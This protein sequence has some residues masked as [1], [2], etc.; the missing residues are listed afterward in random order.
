[1]ALNLSILIATIP[2]RK[3]KF[4]RLLNLLDSQMPMNG[5]IEI[6]WD[7]SL[8]YNIGVKRNKL[9]DRALG[10]YIVFVDDDDMVSDDYVTKILQATKY[11]PDCIG[12]SG[13]ITTNKKNLK[14]W[15]ISKEYG[16]WYEKNN[17]YYRTPNH[18]SPV[19]REIAVKI[20]FPE[21]SFGEDAVYSRNIHPL[22]KTETIV[23]GNIYFYNYSTKNK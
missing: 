4:H 22:L 8:D 5:C 18:I 1:M 13:V 17:V 3:W 14:Q 15:H 23:N 7:D 20:R 10:D 21:I 6:L 2:K 19:K 16:T 9:L 12:I 11:N